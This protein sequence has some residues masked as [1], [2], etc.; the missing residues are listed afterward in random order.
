[1]ADTE[2]PKESMRLSSILEPGD[3]L[4]GLEASD[5]FQAMERLVDLLV[6]R[7]RIP[8]ASREK[9]LAALKEREK[10]KSTGMEFGVAIPH[11]STDEFPDVIGVL[12]IS[13]NGIPYDGPD[14]EKKDILI[15]LHTPRDRFQ[16]HVRTLSAIARLLQDEAF[17]RALRAAKDASEAH[18]V[19]QAFEAKEG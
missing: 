14:G 4:V 13:R 6:A 11:C 19:I 18:R 10:A 7:K 16:L 8:P 9:F 15:L 2:T 5:R 1:M 3:I 12:G 17:R